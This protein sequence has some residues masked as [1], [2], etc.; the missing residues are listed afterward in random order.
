MPFC[1]CLQIPI[2]KRVTRNMG[3]GR[4]GLRSPSRAGGPMLREALA[5]TSFWFWLTGLGFSGFGDPD[6][7]VGGV[8]RAIG[9]VVWEA[10]VMVLWG[11]DP[12]ARGFGCR[13]A[14]D[15]GS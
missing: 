10:V 15:L 11:A 14:V 6:E 4:R 13:I 1:I 3:L 5:P 2:I 12:T 9:V 8:E 7:G